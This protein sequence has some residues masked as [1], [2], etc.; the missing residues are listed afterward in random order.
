LKCILIWS[1]GLIACPESVIPTPGRRVVSTLTKGMKCILARR[2]KY[3]ETPRFLYL[4]DANSIAYGAFQ[5]R[6]ARQGYR[7]AATLTGTHLQK[8]LVFI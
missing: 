5:P 2:F 4:L 6:R 3:Y 8:H 7:L 1:E